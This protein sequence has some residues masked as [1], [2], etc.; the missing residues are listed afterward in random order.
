M[1]NTAPKMFFGVDSVD[2]I[3]VKI[4]NNPGKEI[5]VTFGNCLGNRVF[6]SQ[7]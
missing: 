3:R 5:Y 4:A 6:H 2:V 1:R 7:G